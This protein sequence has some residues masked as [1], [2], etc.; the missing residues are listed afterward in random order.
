MDQ[1][2]QKEGPENK[3][4]EERLGSDDIFENFG[5]TLILSILIFILLSGIVLIILLISRNCNLSEKNK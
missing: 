5:I 1:K 2:S 3:I 4:G